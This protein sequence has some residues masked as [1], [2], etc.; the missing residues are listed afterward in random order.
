MK[1]SVLAFAALSLVSG[2]AAAQSSVTVYGIMDLAVRNLKGADSL[3]QLVNDGRS[4]SRLGFRGVEDIGGGLKAGFNI[5]HGMTPDTGEA[6]SPF[7]GRRATVSLMGSFGEIRLGRHKLSNRT[8]IDDFDPFGSGG[9]APADRIY[10]ALGGGYI[11]RADNQIAYYLP[12]MGGFYGSF[13]TSLGEGVD[14]NKANTF[15]LGYK[16][17][18]L[19]VSA[20]Y[21]QHGAGTKLKTGTLGATYDFGSFV[22]SGM[23][24]KSERGALD[25]DIINL[26]ATV[27]MGQ[28]K[29][30]LSFA[31]ADGNA[32]GT[33]AI[34]GKQIND[35]KLLALGYDYAMSKRTTLYTTVAKVDNNGASTFSL[36]GTKGV[37]APRAATATSNSGD[38]TGYEVGIR[39]SF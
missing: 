29:L 38:S 33:G 6:G 19:H 12:A 17:K 7:W 20:A 13:D 10:S 27:K 35:A 25:Q 24:T 39:H 2:L 11:N 1:K 18:A 30:I 36:A 4:A 32:V 14:A 37:A 26:G 8:I 16:D 22:L 15:R 34:A 5:E 28:G 21:G 31:K 9:I 3:N 23:Y